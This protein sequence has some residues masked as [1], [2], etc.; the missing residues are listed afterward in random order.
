MGSVTVA[1]PESSFSDVAHDGE[2]EMRMLA[3]TPEARGA[4]VGSALVR[5][6]LNI[7]YERGCQAVVMSTHEDMVDARRI[8][9]QNGFVEISERNWV[10][11]E[12]EEL[13]VLM[14]EIA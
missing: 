3:V 1:E 10:P 7:A 12:G 9:E 6:V 4:G 11:P 5:D 14:R 13:V 8:Y 2:L